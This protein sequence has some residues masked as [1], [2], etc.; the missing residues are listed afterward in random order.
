MPV[1]DWDSAFPP[2]V[3]QRNTMSDMVG[4]TPMKL[5]DDALSPGP[6][7]VTTTKKRKLSLSP[8]LSDPKDDMGEP[9]KSDGAAAVAM[10]LD[11]GD[12]DVKISEIGDAKKT[13][14]IGDAKKTVE[15][16][17]EIGEGDT[18]V[19]DDTMSVGVLS[20]AVSTKARKKKGLDWQKA[21]SSDSDS[22][23]SKTSDTSAETTTSKKGLDWRKT[24]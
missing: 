12:A 23:T 7:I 8:D 14:E 18:T 2:H 22:E 16:G 19:A 5:G 13:V 1:F 11:M 17:V 24:K 10:R 4:Q 20:S 6:A 3:V 21:L 9:K 15:I